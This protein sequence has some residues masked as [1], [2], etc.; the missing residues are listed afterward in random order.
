[1]INKTR[2]LLGLV[3]GTATV[4]PL[5][6]SQPAQAQTAAFKAEGVRSITDAYAKVDQAILTNNPRIF[7]EKLAPDFVGY[8]E[9]GQTYNRTQAL[10]RIYAA[11]G[12]YTPGVSVKAIKSKNKILSIKWRGSDAI[13]MVQTTQVLTLRANGEKARLEG[14]VVSR[15]FWSKFKTGWM[16]RQSVVT[17]A[18]IWLDGKKV[19]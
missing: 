9:N 16:G 5:A 6:V 13:V 2:F 12:G 7:E 11:M 3:L 17:Q 8:A 15:E 14:V 1:M 4:F 18:S 10:A 19:R